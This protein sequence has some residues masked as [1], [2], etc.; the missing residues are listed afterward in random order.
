MFMRQSSPLLHSVKQGA[1]QIHLILD[2]GSKLIYLRGIVTNAGA[3]DLLSHHNA[4]AASSPSF[5]VQAFAS[6][7]RNSLLGLT[8][9]D[10]EMGLTG[11]TVRAW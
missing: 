8:A 2:C 10:F 7:E 6:A 9:R 11:V 4:L 1:Y 5:R 3:W